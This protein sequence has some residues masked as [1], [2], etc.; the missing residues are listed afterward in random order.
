MTFTDD[1]KKTLYDA[2]SAYSEARGSAAG[3]ATLSALDRIFE[4]VVSSMSAEARERFVSSLRNGS[5]AI[6]SIDGLL[7]EHAEA[8]VA[9]AEKKSKDS[10]VKEEAVM[11]QAVIESEV[12]D[13]QEDLQQL[14]EEVLNTR[15]E[16]PL[17]MF[18]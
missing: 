16:N 13:R 6:Q 18:F 1:L 3:S 17:T 8:A 10:S 12:S 14:F 7:H 11:E 5:T 9:A 15:I 2:F 4:T